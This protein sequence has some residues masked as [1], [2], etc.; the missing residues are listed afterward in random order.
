MDKF[1]AWAF[2][3][4]GGGKHGD[5]MRVLAGA[6]SA[7]NQIEYVKKYGS[8]KPAVIDEEGFP[9]VT[10]EDFS[11]PVKSIDENIKKENSGKQISQRK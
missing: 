5:L 7:A 10:D 9:A 3:T 4:L 8:A 6:K 2:E 1:C 11:E